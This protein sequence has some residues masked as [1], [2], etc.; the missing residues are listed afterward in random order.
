VALVSSSVVSGVTT[1]TCIALILAMANRVNA[2]MYDGLLVRRKMFS[3]FDGLEVRRTI[4]FVAL[5][6]ATGCKTTYFLAA[7]FA[8]CSA[9]CSIGPTYMKAASGK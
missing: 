3:D 4:S 5:A 8:A 6:N 1:V 9:A 7:I 2:E